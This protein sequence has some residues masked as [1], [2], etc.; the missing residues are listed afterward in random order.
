M[1]YCVAF[2]RYINLT[3]I[4]QMDKSRHLPVMLLP[5]LILLVVATTGL[6]SPSQKVSG[7]QEHSTRRRQDP[8]QNRNPLL[9]L[10]TGGIATVA[11][12]GKPAFSGDGGSATFA[13]LSAARVAI[14]ATGNLFIP[15]TVNHR[16]R[17]IDTKSWI[18]TTV[19]GNGMAGY[20]GDGGPAL[21]ASIAFPNDVAFDEMWNL[22]IAE[23]VTHHVRR[24]DARTGII[25]TVAG[26]GVRDDGNPATKAALNSPSGIAIDKSGNLL[27]ADTGSHRIRKVDA[28]TGIITTIIGDGNNR[29][30]GD[31]DVAIKASLYSPAGLTVDKE[32][33]L[34]IADTGN[35]RIRRVDAATGI[36]TTIAG[37]EYQG[38]SG[39]GNSAIK[40]S[41]NK[42][43][44]VAV[45]SNGNLYIADYGNFRVRQVDA[46][47]R[48]IR[49]V[50]GKGM[51]RY[52]GDKGPAIK[53]GI[54]V[55][56]VAIDENGNLFIAD[57]F[58]HRIRVVKGIAG[59]LNK[60][61]DK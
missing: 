21:N 52:S 11:G 1:K 51:F 24:V 57:G 7:K 38:F 8:S 23:T 13:G 2:I 43:T 14:D 53:A 35:N 45:D 10:S 19:A 59:E 42:P 4:A 49:T 32:G 46:G 5:I 34:F 36:I 39:D 6:Q 50:A 22:F 31:G 33:N 15:D 25:T 41:L 48:I 17:R 30:S 55:T 60:K 37:K 3:D 16:I 44:S 54:G 20:N 28:R 61:V 12:N 26:G 27:I 47:T 40:A 18:I 58:N 9:A 29:F 56:G